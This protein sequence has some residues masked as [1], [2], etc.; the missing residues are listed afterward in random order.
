MT[1]IIKY[2]AVFLVAASVLAWAY[3]SW[4][5]AGHLGVG[6][7]DHE[8]SKRPLYVY[9]GNYR[10]KIN[11]LK[12]KFQQDFGYELLDMDK[13]W[14]PEEIERIQA[15][16]SQ[17]PKSLYQLPGLKGFYRSNSLQTESRDVSG[18]PA[19]TF[20]KFTKVYRKQTE[21]Y[22]VVVDNQSLRIEFYDDLFYESLDDFYNILHHEMGHV[23]DLA[24]GFLSF[25]QEWLSVSQFRILNLPALDGS[26]D[27]DYLYTLLNN[28]EVPHYAP[29]SER[30]LP[31]YSR[32][33]MQED[34]A[35]SFAAYIHYPYFK[36]SHPKRYQYFKKRVF[37]GKEYFSNRHET[38]YVELIISDFNNALMSKEWNQVINI[39]KESS[40]FLNL[41][42][43]AI[44]LAGLK[45]AIE[46]K[47]SESVDVKLAVASCYL[48][49]PGA[50]KF[51]RDLLINGRIKLGGVFKNE[52]CFRLGR[53]AFEDGSARWPMS[54]VFFY[55]KKGRDYIQ[56]LDPVIMYAYARGFKTEYVWRLS[57]AGNSSIILAEGRAGPFTSGNGSVM[58][59]LEG[60]TIGKYGLVEGRELILELGARRKHPR[61]S[62]DLNSNPT[63]IRFLVQPWF[64]YMGPEHPNI[65]IHYP[66]GGIGE[67]KP[68][69]GQ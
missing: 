46:E 57:L 35:N 19:A 12:T 61:V 18:I 1:R 52:R 31:T 64:E 41:D 16:F 15:A 11:Q 27:S 3:T 67:V 37:Q 4:V 48:Y 39:V 63:Q 7:G 26:P 69:S 40:R 65:R 14:V 50:L 43:E 49:H 36:Y 66:V 38:G 2:F 23:F 34:F 55:Q 68:I 5:H 42:V 59:D 44:I 6:A 29:T 53:R 51:R 25:Q 47:I 54:D 28:P 13:G 21:T 24:Y 22:L 58:I 17:L 20:P 33:N 32:Q 9:P 56:F 30:N 8:K 10:D 60:T 45:Q 62:S